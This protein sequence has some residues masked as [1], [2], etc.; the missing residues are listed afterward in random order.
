MAIG[1]MSNVEFL[2][3]LFVTLKLHDDG[4]PGRT[5]STYVH[6]LPAM[7]RHEV[8]DIV[9]VRENRP[10]RPADDEQDTDNTH[11][12]NELA[13]GGRHC[14]GPPVPVAIGVAVAAGGA[15]ES[16]D[17]VVVGG[18]LGRALVGVEVSAG[19]AGGGSCRNWRRDAIEY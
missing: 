6:A 18:G 4:A 16:G 1:E 17:D 10:V 19:A 7:L 9:G 8:L 3:R 14:Y 13:G 15:L 2:V 11:H 12:E 5:G